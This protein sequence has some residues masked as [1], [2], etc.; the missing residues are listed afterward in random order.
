MVRVPGSPL[1]SILLVAVTIMIFV[2]DTFTDLDVAIAVMYVV[3]V[4]LSASVW[5][6]RGVILT[7]I[8]CL[9]LT[10]NA[11][12]SAWLPSALRPSWP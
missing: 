9:M 12:W 6:R 8:A 7:T 11:L 5:K 4:L 3:V 2:V 1:L 10:L